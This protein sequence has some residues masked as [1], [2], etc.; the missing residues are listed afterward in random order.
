M[1]RDYLLLL[2]GAELIPAKNE[3][4]AADAEQIASKILDQSNGD[5]DKALRTF[6]Q[7]SGHIT[8]A[9][10]KQLGPQIR[11]A[12]RARRQINKPQSP[13]DKILSGDVEG[14]LNDMPQ[15]Q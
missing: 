10:E 7:L 6:D 2:A 4:S 15:Q 12:I 13:L 11:K 9:Y 14:G 1:C 3:N 8:D 5:P